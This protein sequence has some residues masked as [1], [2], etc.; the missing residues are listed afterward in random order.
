[1]IDLNANSEKLDALDAEIDS[2]RDE[3]ADSYDALAL[4]EH[5]LLI[6]RETA[7]FKAK[8]NDKMTDITAKSQAVVVCEK[9]LEAVM[10]ADS[11]NKRAQIKLAKAID[12][13]DTIKEQNF[14][15][16]AQMKVFGG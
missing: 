2:A 7:I 11:K 8:Y 15:V 14:C 1:M 6:K 3:V 12:H 4:A 16:R 9:E 10:I 13:K 5:N